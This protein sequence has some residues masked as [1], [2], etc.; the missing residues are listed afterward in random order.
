PRVQL[1]FI[2]T[3]IKLLAIG[4]IGLATILHFQPI[5]VGASFGLFLWLALMLAIAIPRID[6]FLVAYQHWLKRFSKISIS[7]ISIVIIS[8]ALAISTILIWETINR[9][10]LPPAVNELLAD[11]RTPSDAFALTIQAADNLLSGKNPYKHANI[12]TAYNASPDTYRLTPLRLGAFETSFPYPTNEEIHNLWNVAI[13]NPDV[14]Q[15]EIESK[16]NYPA[17]TFLLLVPFLGLGINDI[18]IILAILTLPVLIYAAKKMPLRNRW[19]FIIGVLL[20]FEMWNALFGND[21]RMLYIPFLLMGWLSAPRRPWL[22]AIFI[23]IAAASKQNIWFLLPFYFILMH[24][25]F[26]RR[27]ALQCIVIVGAVFFTINAPFI[28]LDFPLYISSVMAPMMDPIFP[29]GNGLVALVTS[30]IL[31]WD[32]PLFFTLMQI[33]VFVICVFWYFRHVRHSPHAGI[34]LSIIPLFFAWRSLWGYFYF[35]DIILLASIL[36]Y[37]PITNSCPFSDRPSVAGPVSSSIFTPQAS[38]SVKMYL[39]SSFV[40]KASMKVAILAPSE[41]ISRSTALVVVEN[42]AKLLKH[43]ATN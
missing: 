38:S 11:I 36:I 14:P 26:S 2:A 23:G 20:S 4:F 15:P 7:I 34:I 12:I 37:E 39:L 1:F 33:V 8:Q 29:M 27:T 9:D 31:R 16:F 28:V 24:R 3:F 6:T 13:T 35:Y 42:S 30:G 5:V 17:G 21:I 32:A 25:T 41:R 43:E 18:H 40:K 22:S 19:L 10:S